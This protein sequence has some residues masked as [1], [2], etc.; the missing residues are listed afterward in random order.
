MARHFSDRFENDS[1]LLLLE[2]VKSTYRQ[3]EPHLDPNDNDEAERQL[4]ALCDLF[5][6][7][8]D[9]VIQVF[10]KASIPKNF[11]SPSEKALLQKISHP[12]FLD[13]T[14]DYQYWRAVEFMNAR[15]HLQAQQENVVVEHAMYLFN[16]MFEAGKRIALRGLNLADPKYRDNNVLLREL[17][18]RFFSPNLASTGEVEDAPP[19]QN[20]ID[21]VNKLGNIQ[22]P[23]TRV[24]ARRILNA[25]V[26]LDRGA[27]KAV[28]EV[29][30]EDI[31]IAYQ[32]AVYLR[33]FMETHKI[34]GRITPKDVFDNVT[35]KGSVKDP[36]L[37][38]WAMKIVKSN[39]ET[40][41]DSLLYHWDNHIPADAKP[42]NDSVIRAVLAKLEEVDPATRLLKLP[43][44][45]IAQLAAAIRPSTDTRPSEKDVHDF[46][47]SDHPERS[48]WEPKEGKWVVRE[49]SVFES[50]YVWLGYIK[51]EDFLAPPKDAP[52]VESA[53]AAAVET[54][55]RP[56]LPPPD[57]YV[58]AK[59]IFGADFKADDLIEKTIAM[60]KPDAA[61][62]KRVRADLDAALRSPNSAVRN[63]GF[64][65]LP[66]L[67][68]QW[69]HDPYAARRA[70]PRDMMEKL[71]Q[72]YDMKADAEVFTN[73]TYG[74]F[75]LAVVGGAAEKAVVGPN[76]AWNGSADYVDFLVS[77]GFERDLGKESKLLLANAADEVV[78]RAFKE[79]ESF[80][81]RI[82]RQET[83][84]RQKELEAAKAARDKPLERSIERDIQMAGYVQKAAQI[85]N[86]SPIVLLGA[87]PAGTHFGKVLKASLRQG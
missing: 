38:A 68:L 51:P 27:L 71:A 81:A 8:V 49:N 86:I 37:Q 40:A 74:A 7:K 87:T 30:Q 54:T 76:A 16:S 48:A 43:S 84:P 15:A 65:S 45:S 20:P 60:I 62:A 79:F 22:D 73:S 44:F 23:D 53:K 78:N 55:A 2:A 47:F 83:V 12:T 61:N 21:I 67:W 59:A 39:D 56:T 9:D 46:M 24:L 19:P 31:D 25:F 28:Q 33:G 34:E 63:D 36:I 82:D 52:P 5:D 85:L 11:L 80:F 18:N 10:H 4:E 1:Y 58:A 6:V 14:A 41:T 13:L 26:K 66:H 35:R 69:A 3:R 57:P 75:M 42:K 64:P 17:R 77:I 32:T 50:L 29:R 70:S 72:F